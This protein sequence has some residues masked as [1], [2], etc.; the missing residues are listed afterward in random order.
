MKFDLHV[1][2]SFSPDAIGSPAAICRAALRKGLHGFALTDHDT[3]DGW[4][5]VGRAAETAGLLF[6][7]GVERKVSVQGRVVGEVLCLFLRRPVR[8]DDLEAVLAETA[9][10][11]GLAVAAH[12][13][14]RR[15]PALGRS[16]A[17]AKY[18]DRLSL[19]VLNGRAYSGRGN[20]EAAA[21]AAEHA[22]PTTAGSDAHTP[23]EVGNAC[24]E[25]E[26]GTVEDLIRAIRARDVW[27]LGHVSHPL[28]SVCSG[29]RKLG[30]GA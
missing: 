10:Q 4:E 13:F 11:D 1:H 15:R 23:F 7:P 25:A 14:D 21:C 5:R 29:I 8:S 17:F 18:M 30:L 22:L 2:S 28:F 12:P 6:I 24:V 3:T 19:E 16:G 26:V 20:Q 27:V 9:E